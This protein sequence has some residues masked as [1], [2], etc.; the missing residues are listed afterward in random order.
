MASKELHEQWPSRMGPLDFYLFPFDFPVCVLLLEILRYFF[1]LIVQRT[2]SG[3]NIDHPFICPLK[4]FNVIFWLQ[5]TLV[6]VLKWVFVMCSCY[7]GCYWFLNYL[8]S[9][10]WYFTPFLHFYVFLECC[11]QRSRHCALPGPGYSSALRV[12]CWVIV[13]SSN[14]S[15]RLTVPWSLFLWVCLFYK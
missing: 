15:R 7:G 12:I 13:S 4:C 14:S 6:C 5:K 9:V 1:H 11:T 8:S 2:S 10:N 3:L